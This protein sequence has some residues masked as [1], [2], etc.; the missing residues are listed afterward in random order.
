MVVLLPLEHV[1]RKVAIIEDRL[2]IVDVGKDSIT[3]GM[4]FLNRWTWHMT[5]KH[6]SQKNYISASF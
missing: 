4:Y 6:Y 5:S 2:C 1:A 3:T